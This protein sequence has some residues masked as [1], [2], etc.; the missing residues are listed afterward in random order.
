MWSEQV[1]DDDYKDD[2]LFE[3]KPE[4]SE[5]YQC[6]QDLNDAVKTASLNSMLMR[7]MRSK[8]SRL[9]TLIQELQSFVDLQRQEI[10]SLQ[11]ASPDKSV[12]LLSEP[13][14]AGQLIVDDYPCVGDSDNNIS[15]SDQPSNPTLPPA[16]IPDNEVPKSDVFGVSSLDFLFFTQ[17]LLFSLTMSISSI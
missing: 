5:L 13:L 4:K 7:Y 17:I 3:E 2:N 9:E 12:P 15:P 10:E 8:N 1:N 6:H 11:Q 14:D 16:F